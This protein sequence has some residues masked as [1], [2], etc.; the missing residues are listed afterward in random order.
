MTVYIAFDCETTSLNNR[1]PESLINASWVVFDSAKPTT[2]ITELPHY[3][4]YIK[5]DKYVVELDTLLTEKL[6]T[7][8]ILKKIR[9]GNAEF[10]IVSLDEWTKYSIAFIKDH[11]KSAKDWKFLIRNPSFDWHF[12]PRE[13]KEALFVSPF[14]VVDP[15]IMFSTPSDKYGIPSMQTCAER[16]GINEIVPHNAYEDNVL[17]LKTFSF[18]LERNQK[19]FL[20]TKP[21]TVAKIATQIT[22]PKK[23]TVISKK[24][25][26]F[27]QTE[28]I[29]ITAEKLKLNV[30]EINKTAEQLKKT[31]SKKEKYALANKLEALLLPVFVDGAF[32]RGNERRVS[33]DIGLPNGGRVEVKSDGIFN[34]VCQD[35]VYNEEGKVTDSPNVF[36]EMHKGASSGGQSKAGGF[37]QAG[38]QN[39][40]IYA[41]YG[42][43]S[44]YLFIL[45]TDNEELRSALSKGYYGNGYHNAK[46]ITANRGYGVDFRTLLQ[47]PGVAAIDIK[48]MVWLKKPESEII[49][50]SLNKRLFA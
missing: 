37:R 47:L 31:E 7:V 9:T 24:P 21:P 27:S 34:A 8:D 33:M 36:I 30:V 10:P 29:K 14:Q 50:S 48:N 23:T 2:P 11:T 25:A 32:A 15:A 16:S 4:A 28:T 46:N 19:Q 18:A 45:D 38:H 49:K 1:S 40:E 35:K 41:I 39:T 6:Q 22:E 3:S 42:Y 13:I 20:S 43:K 5:Q 12:I 17:M 44:S 26:A